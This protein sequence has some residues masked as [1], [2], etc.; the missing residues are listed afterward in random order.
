ME[1][2]S[3]KYLEIVG[4]KLTNRSRKFTENNHKGFIY[5]IETKCKTF[6]K[7]GF[8]ND[9]NRR[10]KTIDTDCPLQ[11]SIVNFLRLVYL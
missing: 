8:S 9:P 5:L 1:I 2:L 7:I 10:V 3:S 6:Y 4:K 11:I